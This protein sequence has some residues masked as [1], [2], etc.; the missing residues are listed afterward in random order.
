[1][2]IDVGKVRELRN[3]LRAQL[4]DITPRNTK[5][6]HETLSAAMAILGEV[7]VYRVLNSHPERNAVDLFRE[8]SKELSTASA[9][10]LK[11][12]IPG[13]I[14]VDYFRTPEDPR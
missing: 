6:S 14:T 1:M 3:N 13:A 2:D 11:R 7:L 10:F 4:P 9:R 5:I 8:V 12:N